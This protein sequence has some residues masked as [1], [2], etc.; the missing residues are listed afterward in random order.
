MALYSL[1]MRSRKSGETSATWLCR[2]AMERDRCPCAGGAESYRREKFLRATNSQKFF[3][4]DCNQA[5]ANSA[6]SQRCRLPDEFTGSRICQASVNFRP[7]RLSRR[8]SNVPQNSSSVSKH[9]GQNV[10]CMTLAEWMETNESHL[11]Q[12]QRVLVISGRFRGYSLFPTMNM[13]PPSQ[14]RP[15]DSGDRAAPETVNSHSV[16]LKKFSK[17]F[18]VTSASSSGI[19]RSLRFKQAATAARSQSKSWLG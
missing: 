1:V 15:E 9:I 10:S 4:K 18:A 2:F 3:R 17:R 13:S 11:W 19:A 8:L 12:C 5:A 6:R 14:A 7:T 16:E